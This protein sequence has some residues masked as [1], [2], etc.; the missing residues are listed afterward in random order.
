MSLS[1]SRQLKGPVSR[2]AV[3]ALVLTAWSPNLD[4]WFAL[5]V[6]QGEMRRTSD[7]ASAGAT[8][9]DQDAPAPEDS[10]DGSSGSSEPR[11]RVKGFVQVKPGGPM[12][13]TEVEVVPSP[14]DPLMVP[15][16]RIVLP[17]DDLV[18]GVSIGGR[19]VAYP[20]R[21]LAM[22]EVVDAHVGKTPVAPS[23]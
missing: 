23:W 14:V 2:I 12:W 1:R 9:S 5:A 19:T 22:Y 17:D 15:A 7:S 10:E 21:F 4:S 8:S 16:D 20:I 11:R 18:L 6:P 13:D 3:L